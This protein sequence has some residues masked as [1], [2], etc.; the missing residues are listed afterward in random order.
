MAK[1]LNIAVLRLQAAVFVGVVCG[2]E[3]AQA[4]VGRNNFSS[5][6]ENITE[7]IAELPGLLTGVSYLIGLLMGVLGIMK[8]K[9]HVEN[10]TQT[11]L[12]DGAIRMAAGGALFGLPIIY[13]AMFTTIGNTSYQLRP[14]ELNAVTFNVR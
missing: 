12:K 14:A 4:Q 6:A 1:L 10:P 9:D 13:E 7:S 2:A 8:I 5:I 3:A 11:A